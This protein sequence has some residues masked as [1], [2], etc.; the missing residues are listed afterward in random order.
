MTDSDTIFQRVL[1]GV[2][3]AFV[4]LGVYS[5]NERGRTLE[6]RTQAQTNGASADDAVKLCKR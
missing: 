3:S 1:L 6:C 5:Y 2:I 4:A